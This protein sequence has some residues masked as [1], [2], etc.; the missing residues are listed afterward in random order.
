MKLL[1]LALKAA[2]AFAV[3]MITVGWIIIALIFIAESLMFIADKADNAKLLMMNRYGLPVRNWWFKC[4]REYKE[5]KN[6][7]K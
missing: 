7:L 4:Y 5:E 2:L 1:F 3:M 6:R